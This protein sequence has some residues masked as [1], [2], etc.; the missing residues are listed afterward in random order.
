MKKFFGAFCCFA[1]VLFFANSASA[2]ARD[3]EGV[4]DNMGIQTKNQGE[5]TQAKVQNIEQAV[6]RVQDENAT[7][8][9]KE[10][11]NSNRGNGN[12]ILNT[13]NNATGTQNAIVGNMNAVQR[14]SSVANAVKEMLQ[15][16]DRSGGIGE[17][18]RVIAQSQN[19]NEEKIESGI[20]KIES[21]GSL[22]KFFIGPNYSEINS[23]KKVLEQNKEHLIQLNEIKTQLLNEVDQQM[24]SEKV[25]V[26]EQNNLEI[27]NSLN[28]SEKGFS[29]LGWMFRFFAK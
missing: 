20:E 24:L 15:I 3:I 2:I 13:E 5:E 28:A 29:L 17:Q 6:L 7:G 23:I 25:R 14:R 18:V 19:Q 4:K 8:T 26:F 27:E 21:R 9:Q 1:S 10:N 16:A 22:T 12:Q 11:Q